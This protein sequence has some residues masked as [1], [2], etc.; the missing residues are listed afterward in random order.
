[1]KT[2]KGVI[3]GY[4]GVAAVDSKH[5]VIVHGEAYGSGA[6]Q[7]TLIPMVKAIDSHYRWLGCSDVL[8][9]AKIVAD[10]GFHSKDNLESLM[11]Q[12][13]DA[14]IADNQFRQRDP[15]FDQAGRYRVQHKKDRAAFARK[16]GKPIASGRFT[17]KDFL[18]DTQSMTCSCPASKPMWLS[19]E[20]AMI[21]GQ[22]GY[23]FCGYVHQ[24]KS[25][26]LRAQCLRKAD[27]KSPR[28]V[29]FF[30]KQVVDR[31]KPDAV[32]MMKDKIDSPPGKRIYGKRLAV[33]EPPFAQMQ[34]MGLTKLT[35]RGRE[36]VNGQ[37]QLMC[38]LHNLKKI[39]GYG[40]EK[41]LK[42]MSKAENR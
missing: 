2:S 18:F 38:A 39:H 26:P 27:Q 23:Q 36:K 42:W 37:W 16:S 5:Q 6:E 21:G 7:P 1:M 33:A 20:K 8:K 28:S 40:G 3:Q 34:E 14:Y 12:N 15:N 4:C 24:C 13:V 41:L 29:V 9:T 22:P 25:C 11:K 31:Q 10:S 17:T 19:S 35:L 32:Q 30:Y